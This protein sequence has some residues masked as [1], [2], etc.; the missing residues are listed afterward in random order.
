[1]YIFLFA[2]AVGLACA[3]LPILPEQ[4]NGEWRT[5]FMASDNVDKIEDG[6]DLKAFLRHFQC[7]QGCR[8]LSARFYIKLFGECRE[9]SALGIKRNTNGP[10][11]ADYAGQNSFEIIDKGDEDIVFSST[12]VDVRGRRTRVLLMAGKR[13]SITPEQERRFAQLTEE[14]GI[15]REN[16]KNILN[17]DTCPN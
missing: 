11:V 15:P 1:M 8:K 17:S 16:I 12:N 4:I 6:G 2:L 3:H 9:V 5:L 7:F 10:Y 13:N 14:N